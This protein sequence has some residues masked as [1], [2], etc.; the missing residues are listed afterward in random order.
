MRFD[1][2]PLYS[3]G[4]PMPFQQVAE[5]MA[6]E[7]RF[8]EQIGF[9]GVWVG[10]HH[11]GTPN[12]DNGAPNPLTMLAWLAARTESIRLGTMPIVLPDHHPVSVAEEAAMVDQVSCGRLDLSVGRGTND[13]ASG[14]FHAA[15][16]RKDDDTNYELFRESLEVI[17]GAW[18][19]P[20]L[21]HDGRFFRFP[22]GR[23][24]EENHRL[25]EAQS[26]YYGPEGELV[27]L[28]VRPKP[29]QQPH[30]PVWLASEKLKS[31]Q[32]AAERGY[33]AFPG[34]CTATAPARTGAPTGRSHHASKAG[35]CASASGWA[36]C[37]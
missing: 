16:L 6:E 22:E 21:R 2:A 15:A 34:A 32:W 26:R 19:Q 20:A 23:W 12:Q 31:H 10:E 4:T 29:F 25:R 8:V 33:G 5:Q 30:P 14:Q 28:D 24:R 27:G 36:C 13:R 35:S 18:T 3:P 37:R 11:F 1:L 17:I 9:G 7:A